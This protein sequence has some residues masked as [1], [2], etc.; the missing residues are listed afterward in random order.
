MTPNGVIVA[1]A[2][3]VALG[4]SD[5]GWGRGYAA[6]CWRCERANY[7]LGD[8]PCCWKRDSSLTSAT[9]TCPRK[10]IAEGMMGGGFNA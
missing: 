5:W 6:S 3:A 10:C 8:L 1:A 7:M 2:F 4:E 9:E